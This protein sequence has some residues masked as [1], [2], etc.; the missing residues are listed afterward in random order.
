MIRM[1]QLIYS[2]SI[3][4]NQSAYFC[5]VEKNKDGRASFKGSGLY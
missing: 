1:S 2:D 3:D 5:I 4:A